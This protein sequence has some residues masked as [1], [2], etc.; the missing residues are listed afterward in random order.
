MMY[1]AKNGHLEIVR[2]A[3]RLRED[4]DVSSCFAGSCWSGARF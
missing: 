2:T 1:A 3:F 4:W